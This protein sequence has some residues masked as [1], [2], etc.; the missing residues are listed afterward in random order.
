MRAPRALSCLSKH[1]SVRR[2]LYD[3]CMPGGEVR[4][5]NTKCGNLPQHP[6]LRGVSTQQL[7]LHTHGPMY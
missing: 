3:Q 2:H 6:A 5:A 1:L 4:D 7:I